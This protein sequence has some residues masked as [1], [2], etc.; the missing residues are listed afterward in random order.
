MGTRKRDRETFPRERI[1][2]NLTGLLRFK[3]RSADAWRIVQLQPLLFSSA[4]CMHRTG[5]RTG[6]ISRASTFL[7]TFEFS[8]TV[9]AKLHLNCAAA[10]ALARAR[11]QGLWTRARAK[12]R[13][14]RRVRE[15]GKVQGERG[16]EIGQNTRSHDGI[17]K[18]RAF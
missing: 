14:L 3:L 8:F 7:V 17:A 2:S 9:P 1:N 4:Y 11:E 5:L 12:K 18:F 6:D 16:F 10:E 13:R 15:V